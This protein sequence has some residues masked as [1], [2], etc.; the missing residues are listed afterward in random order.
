MT[1][2]VLFEADVAMAVGDGGRGGSWAE[3]EGKVGDRGRGTGEGR[4]RGEGR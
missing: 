3:A 4:R 2:D 1:V